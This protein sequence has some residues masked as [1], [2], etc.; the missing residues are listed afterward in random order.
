MAYI[1][2]HMQNQYS[3]TKQTMR[4]AMTNYVNVLVAAT[5][6]WPL[7]DEWPTEKGY[8]LYYAPQSYKRSNMEGG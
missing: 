7:T 1:L 8:P 2:S 6:S 4:T 5:A 3:S